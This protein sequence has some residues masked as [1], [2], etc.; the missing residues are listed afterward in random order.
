MIQSSHNDFMNDI[1]RRSYI[2]TRKHDMSNSLNKKEPTKDD[3]KRSKKFKILLLFSLLIVIFLVLFFGIFFGLRAKKDDNNGININNNLDH[4]RNNNADNV[5]DNSINNTLDN[6]IDIASENIDNIV[7][8]TVDNNGD[9]LF[10][11][12]DNTYH[13]D[14]I[15]NKDDSF[16]NT[17]NT[18]DISMESSIINT[19]YIDLDTKVS[20]STNGFILDSECMNK[21]Y[22]FKATYYTNSCN[23]TVKLMNY[24]PNKVIDMIVDGIQEN[25]EQ[26]QNNSYMFQSKGKHIVCIL[27]NITNCTSLENFFLKIKNMISI[28][29]TS[30]FN[31]ENVE[32]M[33]AMF[34]G[35]SSLISINFSNL[36]TKNVKTMEAMLHSCKSLK[37][38]DFSNLDLRNVEIMYKFYYMCDSLVSVNFTNTTTLN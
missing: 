3:R 35:C 9:N 8:D 31:T 1:G 34:M 36:N 27:I 25:E 37:S 14:T 28:S 6:N 33:D 21:K 19:H 7:G 38:I 4:N 11:K 18:F 29:F 32:Y 23:E 2:Y 26:K 5:I 22:S 15:D 17:D 13:Y 24:F 30:E 20:D 12:I 10:E 16:D